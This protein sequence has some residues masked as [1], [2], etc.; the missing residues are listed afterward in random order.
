[1]CGWS[2]ADLVPLGKVVGMGPRAEAVGQAATSP[3]ASPSRE[4][5]LAAGCTNHDP[6]TSAIP[7]P[8]AQP[9]LFSLLLSLFFLAEYR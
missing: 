5:G 6:V 8:A 9:N 1:M 4:P 3:C 2:P 7:V